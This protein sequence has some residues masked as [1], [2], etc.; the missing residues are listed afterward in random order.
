MSKIPE[1][2]RSYIDEESRSLYTLEFG[3][4]EEVDEANRRALVSLKTDEDALIDDVP[5][6]APFA[7][8][9]YGD[10]VP[11]V[12]GETEGLL[13]FNMSPLDEIL[14]E[15]GH[16]DQMEDRHHSLQDAIFFPQ[17]FYDTDT[18]PNHDPGERLIAHPSGSLFRMRPN[19]AIRLESSSGSYIQVGAQG[20]GRSAPML[21]GLLQADTTR[22]LPATTRYNLG[23]R[24][25]YIE[26][27]GIRHPV[28]LN[29]TA[30]LNTE[31]D[32]S[33]VTGT[34]ANAVA[35]S[36]GTAIPGGTG[37]QHFVTAYAWNR[38]AQNHFSYV[39]ND[40]GVHLMTVDSATAPSTVIG[41]GEASVTAFNSDGFD[42]T[43]SS[44]Y[45]DAY[46]IYWKAYD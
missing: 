17:V 25:S 11:I 39:G 19:G 36:Y 42:L 5:I 33:T 22:S 12:P 7:G 8:D 35:W 32:S 45:E 37:A 43:W 30:S 31:Y 16:I 41:R 38:D 1:L 21:Q 40:K 18:I 2:I 23:F 6:A 27:Y 3:I 29:E 28:N 20:V 15:R 13:L 9:G 24:P 10:I 26:L 4:V 46:Y 44:A 14:T 34:E